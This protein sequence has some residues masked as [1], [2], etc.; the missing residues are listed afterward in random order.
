ML[1]QICL[2][3]SIIPFSVNAATKTDSYMKDFCPGW[4]DRGNIFKVY[5]DIQY[6]SI[7]KVLVNKKKSLIIYG[8]DDNII[9]FKAKR[10]GRIKISITTSSGKVINKIIT[11]REMNYTKEEISLKTSLIN[12]KKKLQGTSAEAKL[13]WKTYNNPDISGYVIMKKNGKSKDVIDVT[14]D[15]KKNYIYIDSYDVKSEFIVTPYQMTGGRIYLSRDKTNI[16]RF[17]NSRPVVT[18]Q[19]AIYDENNKAMLEV[20]WGK[21]KGADG[22]TILRGETNGSKEK[23]QYVKQV[24]GNV[25]KIF[26]KYNS[27]SEFYKFYVIAYKSIK[28]KRFTTR[29]GSNSTIKE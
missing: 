6:G 1:L 2:L 7:E 25:D 26:V 13:V 8:I 27:N 22:Y 10:A 16:N 28:G 17:Q 29:I 5:T 18:V 24:K 23:L 21:I 19:G 12:D 14:N 11:I 15:P 20:S 9:T 4:V 3:I